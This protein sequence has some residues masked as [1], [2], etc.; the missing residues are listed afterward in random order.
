MKAT[1]SQAIIGGA[2]LSFLS[3]LS[4]AS[5]LPP[6]ESAGDALLSPP[7][8]WNIRCPRDVQDYCTP[9]NRLFYCTVNGELW[10]QLNASCAA[11]VCRDG[12]GGRP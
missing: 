5:P 8:M 10:N 1:T 6:Q 7:P 3:A 9:D 2:L 11:C 4:S 12:S